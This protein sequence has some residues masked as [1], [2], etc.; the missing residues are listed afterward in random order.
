M[1]SI[2]P[3]RISQLKAWEL[4]TFL[5]KIYLQDWR[6]LLSNYMLSIQMIFS[7]KVTTNQAE[8]KYFGH[9][10]SAEITYVTF[11][12]SFVVRVGDIAFQLLLLPSSFFPCW[13]EYLHI[14]IKVIQKARQWVKQIFFETV[15]SDFKSLQIGGLWSVN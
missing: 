8:I 2:I 1:I 9:L 5:L 10:N 7:S 14:H 13:L 15:N 4:F 12:H 3:S 6:T 11:L